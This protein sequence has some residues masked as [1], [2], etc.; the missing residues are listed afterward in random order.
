MGYRLHGLAQSGNCYKVS[1]FLTLV[2]AEWEPVL[3]DIYAG[4]ARTPEFLALN[5]MG[6]VPVL[7]TPTGP[8]GRREVLTQT[9]AILT[10][11]AR[12]VG[13]FGGESPAEQDEILRWLLWDNHKL[14][15]FTAAQRFM[16]NFLPEAQRDP[17]LLAF[18][19][20]RRRVAMKILE[21]RLGAQEWV[22]L[23]NRPTIADLSCCAYLFWLEM[24]GDAE[25]NWP[26]TARW[27]DRIRA[28]PGWAPAATLLPAGDPKL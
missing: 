26:A 25:A 17:T 27:L 21:G 16:A 8:D 28:L 4:Q 1:L 13:R 20:G 24:V 10:R 19:D 15:H 7:Q 23:P 9:G 5:P 11:L 2:G 18:F 3:V 14:T 22:A 6:E 12:D